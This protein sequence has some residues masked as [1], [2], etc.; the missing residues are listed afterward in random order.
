MSTQRR[1]AFFLGL[2]GALITLLTLV[3]TRRVANAQL[4][5]QAWLPSLAG[6][7]SS[8]SIPGSYDWP[9]F[10][11]DQRH[12]GND[13]R[14]T[15]INPGNVNRLRL[16]YRVPL[17][18]IADG[19]PAYLTNVASAAGVKDVLYFTTLFGHL[20]ALDAA[21]GSVVWAAPHPPTCHINGG[22]NVCYTTSSP[23]IDP[24][25]QFVYTFGDDGYVHKHRVADGGEVKGGGW[26]ELASTKPVDEKGSSALS[27]AGGYL[28]AANSGYFGD[29]GDYQ[30]HISAIN[31]ATGGQTVFNLNCSDQGV[32]F[33]E[34]PGTPDCPAVQSAVWARPGVVYDSD[35]GRL[36]AAS[37]NGDFNPGAHDWGDTVIALAPSG[38]G[39]GGNP[40]DTYTP[41]NFTQLQANDLDLGSTA[42]A[43]LP[44][45][46]NSRIPHVGVQGG[47]DS[48]LR[49]LNLD[50]LSQ[51]GGPGHVGGEIVPPITLPQGG[52]VL[53][54]P[55]VWTNPANHSVWVFV[56]NDQGA[57]GFRVVVG[58]D[59][60]PRL[61]PA[62][63]FRRG[64]ASP[65]IAG[66]VLFYASSG[67]IQ[68]L[69][70]SSGRELWQS[71]I[72]PVHWESPIVVGG[73]VY[74]TD[75]TGVVSAFSLR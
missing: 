13:T 43:I 34:Q 36:Y 74:I 4:S 44:V 15:A 59:R 29:R 1:T 26:P 21:N 10:N 73:R 63:Q 8:A 41:A 75:Q 56:A 6:T 11:F 69:D 35:T 40:L 48:L 39:S 72:G 37:G 28:L 54:Q 45:L 65:V 53:T 58:S 64:G 71:A 18:D 17:G 42:P 22:P 16:L 23:A 2:T 19:A 51:Q 30:G 9:Q 46:P 31:L 14:E 3:A 50:N 32:H 47:K 12:S 57:S 25:R 62:W 61:Q 24:N 68:A 7:A 20:V 67:T 49:L 52:E 27:I 60:L 33:V 66:N 70:P 5:I 55:A 38:T